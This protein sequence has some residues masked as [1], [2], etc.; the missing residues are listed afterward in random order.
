MSLKQTSA[1]VT[2]FGFV[3]VFFTLAVLMSFTDD[4][5]TF[6]EVKMKE[7][8]R[9]PQNIE[10]E[11]KLRNV[12]SVAFYHIYTKGS[13]YNEI[14]HEQML[15]LNKSGVLDR[16]DKVFYTTIGENGN[17][18]NIWHS[19]FNKLAHFDIGQET[20]TLRYLYDYCI[21]L[22]PEEDS[23]VL[24]FHTKGS[25]HST[26]QNDRMRK[27]LNYFAINTGCI[28]VLENYDTCGARYKSV[29]INVQ[30]LRY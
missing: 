27:A 26:V 18:L 2:I 20:E 29:T 13:N 1:N 24:Y 15:H 14:I 9:V 17:D 10:V 7:V 4:I 16:L 21:K 25:F 12:H 6:M 5:D 22:P 23:N 11:S 28:E 3:L 8:N 19:K 30:N